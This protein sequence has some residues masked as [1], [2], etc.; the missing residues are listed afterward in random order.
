MEKFN[1]LSQA[2]QQ[3]IYAIFYKI[4]DTL[5]NILGAL[6]ILLFGWLIARSLKYITIKF[7]NLSYLNSTIVKIIGKNFLQNNPKINI[8]QI[9]GNVVY[10]LIILFFIV[11]GTETLGWTVV[12]L[13]VTKIIAY[14]PKLF[15]AALVFIIGLY[16]ANFIKSFIAGTFEML[17]LQA[18]K[19]V[20][21]AAYYFILV[22]IAITALNQ[23]GIDTAAIN[24]NF[25]III[26]SILFAFA[27]AFGLGAKETFSNI[28]NSFY[29]K[30]TFNEG[31]EIIINEIEGVIL[32]INNTSVSIKTKKEVF[33]VPMNV[34]LLSVVK[35]NNN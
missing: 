24:A 32:K 3:S 22:L 31:D 28:L 23:A 33:I 19:F 11:F 1:S 9:L 10:W 35:I 8:A 14:L 4:A 20:A 15:A 30:K 25:T 12:S 27:L 26:S 7:F 6:I 13:E 17:N 34:F 2:L 16:I 5:P 29:A 18:G 21:N